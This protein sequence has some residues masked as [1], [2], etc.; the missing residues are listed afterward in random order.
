MFFIILHEPLVKFQFRSFVHLVE[1]LNS[2]WV[3]GTNY[4][5]KNSKK[6]TIRL[7]VVIM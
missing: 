4:Q 2:C 3:F 1:K 6:K 7:C 5:T